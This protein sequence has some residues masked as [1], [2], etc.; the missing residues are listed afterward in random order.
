MKNSS[1]AGITVVNEMALSLYS[2]LY[3]TKIKPPILAYT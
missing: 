1:P 3:D 2:D